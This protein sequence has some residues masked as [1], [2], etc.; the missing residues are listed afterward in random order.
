LMHCLGRLGDGAEDHGHCHRSG[1]AEEEK[2]EE[3]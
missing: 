3:S 2:N 1:E